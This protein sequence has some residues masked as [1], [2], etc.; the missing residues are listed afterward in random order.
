MQMKLLVS[1]G[2]TGG[3]FFPALEVLKKA[4]DRGISTLYV[5]AERGIE[6]S[7]EHVIPG[8]KMLLELYPF[9]GVS[10][11]RRFKALL[12]FWR[13]LSHVRHHTQGD[14]KA[15]VF[16]GYP[17]VPTGAHAI[18][19]GKPLY[20]HE[21]NSVPSMTNRI[22]SGFSKKVFITFEYSRKFFKGNNV[23]RTGLPIR[24]EL[25]S[26]KIE[27]S[28]AKEA[29]GFKPEAP[30][31]LF[32]GGSQG[33]R[34]INNLAVD[35]AKR[36]DAPT[37]LLSGE[38]DFERVSDIAQGVEN[39]KVFPFRTDM[40]LVYSASEVA[41]C[42]SGAGTLSE[43]SYFEVPAV[44]IPYPYASGDHQFYN[45]KEVE[46]LGGA[47]TLRQEDVNLDRVIT[48]VDRIFGNLKS[49]K[50]NIKGFANPEAAELIL[51]EIL[52]D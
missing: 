19:K 4:K 7:F 27:K 41:V 30:V 45:A 26:T 14:F 52:E 9:R 13:G 21:Q 16:G 34:F 8:D 38:T 44:L 10:L 6:K 2:G 49:M 28:G 31:V 32:M 43:L 29:L 25:L 36:T 20:V 3:H 17:S 46:E 1:G 40:G 11:K 22:F 47:Y 42:R 33:A 51:N 23:V 37:I 35:F 39:L 18:L 24:E 48:L 15:L 12:S 5:G 50:A